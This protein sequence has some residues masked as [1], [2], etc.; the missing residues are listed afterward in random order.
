MKKKK[1][2][3]TGWPGLVRRICDRLSRMLFIQCNSV[4]CKCALGR[5]IFIAC[6]LKAVRNDENMFVLMCLVF[7]TTLARLLLLLLTLPLLYTFDVCT[8]S[9]FDVICLLFCWCCCCNSSV[10]LAASCF[11]AAFIVVI[12]LC[13]HVII[14]QTFACRN[15]FHAFQFA[16]KQTVINSVVIKV[17]FSLL[18]IFLHF[19]FRCFSFASLISHSQSH[20]LVVLHSLLYSYVVQ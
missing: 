17:F 2:K 20:Y 8:S 1:K 11:V 14:V 3:E 12:A 13:I 16:R 5:E 15:S 19:F 7:L 9:T 18:L 6:W 10:S 4:M